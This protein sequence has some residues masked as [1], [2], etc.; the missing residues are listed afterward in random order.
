MRILLVSILLMPTPLLAQGFDIYLFD[1]S[2]D[3]T[4]VKQVTDRAGYDNQPAFT[5]DSESLMFSSDRAGEQTDLFRYRLAD[6]QITNLTDTPDENEFSPQPHGENR[7]SYVLQEGNPYQHVWHRAYDGGE[8]QRMLTSY[9]PVGYYTRNDKG[10]LFWGRYAYSV[11]FEPAGAQVGP[12]AGESLYV[13]DQAGRSIHAIPGSSNFSFVHKQSDWNWVI[14]RFDPDTKAMTP[15]VS[16]SADN[17]DYC[18]HPDGFMITA[19]GSKL[20][21]FRPGEDERWADLT[22]LEAPGLDKGGRCAVS[23]DGRYLALV[24]LRH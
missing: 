12:G 14:K 10:V 9:V 7:F 21:A 22:E 6:G 16:I 17:E 18:W 4:L 8:A 23:P 2:Q 11:F 20:L 13:I 1:I 3:Y 15:L 5:L 19:D 24:N